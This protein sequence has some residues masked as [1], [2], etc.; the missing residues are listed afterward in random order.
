MAFKSAIGKE[1][2]DRRKELKITQPEL[3]ELAGVNVNTV[4]RLERGV[5]NPTLDVLVRIGEALGMEVI[6]QVKYKA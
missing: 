5:T 2:R 6:M 4:V 1:I 3:A